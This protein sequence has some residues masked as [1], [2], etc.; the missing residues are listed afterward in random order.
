MSPPAI[1]MKARG[2]IVMESLCLRNG[3]RGRQGFRVTPERRYFSSTAI[4]S[5]G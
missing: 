2:A 3:S 4:L 5:A 1:W